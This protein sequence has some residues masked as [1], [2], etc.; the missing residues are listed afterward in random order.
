MSDSIFPIFNEARLIRKEYRRNETISNLQI[1]VYDGTEEGQRNPIVFNQQVREQPKRQSE[2]FFERCIPN[3]RYMFG[4][5]WTPEYQNQ[6]VI[7][8]VPTFGNVFLTTVDSKIVNSSG[9]III[10]KF[11]I[12]YLWQLMRE[13]CGAEPM[14]MPII[15]SDSI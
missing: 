6:F 3:G 12:N 5:T 1:L 10:D 15:V 2:Q 13:K 9:K 11:W 4:W 8:N 7:K 14:V